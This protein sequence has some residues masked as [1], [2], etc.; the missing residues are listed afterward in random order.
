MSPSSMSKGMSE[1][2]SLQSA[3]SSS[4]TSSTVARKEPEQQA[5]ILAASFLRICLSS[6]ASV[7][8]LLQHLGE[9]RDISTLPVLQSTSRLCSFNQVC[10]RMRFCFPNSVTQNRALSVCSCYDQVHC[11]VLHTFIFSFSFIF[12][13]VTQINT[14]DTRTIRMNIYIMTHV[15]LAIDSW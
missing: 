9:K 15:C 8:H 2:V 4:S 1:A 11:L 10:L 7:Q 12:P 13:F 6:L 3:E 14:A 5:F